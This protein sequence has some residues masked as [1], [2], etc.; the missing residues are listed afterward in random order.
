MSHDEGL[1]FLRAQSW[2][3]LATL[4]ADG[5]VWGDIAACF[6]EGETLYVRIPRRGR[7]HDNIVR[8]PRV[9]CMADQY[10][11]YYEIK[12][13]TV[14]GSAT[15][16]DNEGLRGRLEALDDPLGRHGHEGAVYA[17]PLDDVVSFDFAK[18]KAKV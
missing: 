18:I 2:V 10:P 6:V 9:S 16:V 3:A 12:G 13:V 4:D 15:A 8:D 11:A 17:V 1:E 14:H 7:S 5:G